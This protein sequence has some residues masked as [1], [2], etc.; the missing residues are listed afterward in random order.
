VSLLAHGRS[1]YGARISHDAALARY[2]AA[3]VQE[4]PGF[5]LSAPVTLSICCFRYVPEGLP[6][7]PGREE[8]L[9]RLNARLMTEAQLDG[10]VFF[11]NA[12]LRDRFVLRACIVN[13]R[14]EAGD[15]DAVLDVA[16]E[17]GAGL[18]AELR[19]EGLRA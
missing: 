8:Y 4:R 1:A 6:D 5:E 3:R 13:F 7:G 19:P 17:I 11:S 14:T 16:A 10:R 9:D 12:V 18:D 15:L 2:L